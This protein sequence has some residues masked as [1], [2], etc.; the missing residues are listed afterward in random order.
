[1]CSRK[2]ADPAGVQRVYRGSGGG[3]EGDLEGVFLC[4]RKH[5]DP[6]GVQGV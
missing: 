3:L 2:H 1:M 6:S 4:S 5:A